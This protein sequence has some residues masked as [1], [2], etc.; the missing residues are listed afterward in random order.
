MITQ[1]MITKETAFDEVI[2]VKIK[3]IKETNRQPSYG[4]DHL[5]SPALG[6]VGWTSSQYRR[7]FYDLRAFESL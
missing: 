2:T 6:S 7:G 1:P 5:P 3:Q 4:F